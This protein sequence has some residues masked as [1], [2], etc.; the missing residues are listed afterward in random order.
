MER[1]SSRTSFTRRLNS[2]EHMSTPSQISAEES[3][4]N[5][6]QVFLFTLEALASQAEEQCALMGDFNT[7]W[8]LRDD[9]LA[10]RYLISSAFFTDEQEA[11]VLEFLAAIDPVPVNTMPS[12]AGRTA[13]LA[14]M[15]H[16]AWEPI[17]TLAQQLITVLKPVTRA[18]QAYFK[19]DAESRPFLY[20]LIARVAEVLCFIIVTICILLNILQI[21][22]LPKAVLFFAASAMCFSL[23]MEVVIIYLYPHL[24]RRQPSNKFLAMIC[25]ASLHSHPVRSRSTA[26]GVAVLSLVLFFFALGR[27][28]GYW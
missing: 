9:A 13:N 2:P 21:V 22:A 11:A 27:A 7:A 1:D 17:R 6:Y 8:E 23:F 16:P 20:L 14:A 25:R 18:N 4:H 26:G 24:A 19:A 28:L 3:S 12:G 10:G 15:Q 5:A